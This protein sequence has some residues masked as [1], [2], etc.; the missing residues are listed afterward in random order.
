MKPTRPALRWFGGK[1][2]LA[3][4][5][6]AHLPRHRIYVEP[7]GGAASVLLRKSRSYAEIYN[8]LDDELVSLFRVLR[9]PSSA[10]ELE[11]LLRLTPFAR[12]E[13][14]AA[15]EPTGDPV[16]RARRMIVRSYMGFGANSAATR[17]TSANATGFR[18]SSSRSGTTPAHDWANYPDALSALARRMV[19]VTIEHADAT[20]VMRAHDR[21]DTLH[22]VDPPYLHETRSRRNPYCTKHL[23]RHELSREDHVALLDA[24]RD[25]VGMVVVSG[26]PAPLYDDALAGWRRVE[27]QAFADGARPRT[28][29]L[30]INPAAASALDRQHMPLFREAAE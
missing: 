16:E 23:Y 30:W 13:L 11:R 29:V 2:R 3:P 8:D 24:L 22:Y 10:I 21:A 12:T 1:W 4:W 17:A 25:L 26:Y 19:G 20:K 28:E 27:C 9:D 6:I 14:R 5:V 7:F 18:A 15:Y